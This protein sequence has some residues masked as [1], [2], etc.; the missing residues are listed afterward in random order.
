MKLMD[1]YDLPV[2][3]TV[4][5]SAGWSG[6]SWF[7]K[8]RKGNEWQAYLDDK[9]LIAFRPQSGEFWG[10]PVRMKYEEFEQLFKEGE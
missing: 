5:F 2:L 3:M 1:M 7:G 4:G 6:Y 10:A 8:D 9:S